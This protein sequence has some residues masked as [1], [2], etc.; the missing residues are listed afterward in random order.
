MEDF[1]DVNKV[2]IEDFVVSGA[3]A[4]VGLVPGA[5]FLA[6][7]WA[8]MLGTPLDNRRNDFF[9]SLHERIVKLENEYELDIES[10]KT[11]DSFIDAV[12]QIIP[13]YQS[14]S[15]NLKKEAFK[16]ILTNIALN[17]KI[18][19]AK[20]Q[21]FIR[22]IV[23]MSEGHII[24]LSFLNRPDVWLTNNRG[25]RFLNTQTYF[26]EATVADIF[27]ECR[28]GLFSGDT[29]LIILEDLVSNRLVISQNAEGF[30]TTNYNF[31][32][33]GQKF[34]SERGKEF[35]NFITFTS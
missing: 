10:L 32:A 24:V 23:S 19:D 30:L 11:N 31:G 29:L 35:I 7:Y 6:E 8:L 12:I 28:P 3:K 13:L 1:N 18:E 9:Q 2:R 4:L 14:T 16:N 5:N 20:K 22:L 25:D 15:E 21:Y 34:T 26:Q 17:Y 27:K 33:V